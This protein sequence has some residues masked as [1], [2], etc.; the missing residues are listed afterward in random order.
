VC[1]GTDQS[2][3]VWQ[4]TNEVAVHGVQLDV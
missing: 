3:N 2:G 1:Y 4:C